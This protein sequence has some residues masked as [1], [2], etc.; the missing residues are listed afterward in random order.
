VVTPDRQLSV[1]LPADT[2]AEAVRRLGWL[3]LVYAIANITGPFAKLVLAAAE[4]RVD[5][6]DFAIP[7]VFG[8][9]A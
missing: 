8:L 1:S 5:A 2:I 6:S 3:A 7:D 4:G 9:A